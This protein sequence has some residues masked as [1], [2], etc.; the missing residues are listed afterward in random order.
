[1][2]VK[3]RGSRRSG[4]FPP[5]AFTLCYCTLL[6]SLSPPRLSRYCRYDNTLD[7]WESRERCAL[8]HHLY[9]IRTLGKSPRTR[10]VKPFSIFPPDLLSEGRPEEFLRAPWLP[11]S[12]P[13]PIPECG[14]HLCTL[15]LNLL[16]FFCVPNF[17]L[18]LTLVVG[19]IWTGTSRKT[20]FF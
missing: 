17:V 12:G 5:L 1:M 8:W 10:D 18:T 7:A 6:L 19:R 15:S 2:A 11:S 4:F 13:H 16:A 9:T 14:V 3:H 20:F